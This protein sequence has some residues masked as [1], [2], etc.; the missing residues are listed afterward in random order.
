[1]SSEELVGANRALRAALVAFDPDELSGPQC[2]SLVEELAATEKACAVARA[3]AAARA[4]ACGS[5]K[6]H[7]FSDAAEWLARASG[8]TA[9]E[10]KAA[11]E[12]GAALDDCPQTK[13]AALGGE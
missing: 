2:A 1:M 11:L 4:A 8:T 5:H 10:A 13:A 9:G 3:R 6:A 7:G 12:T